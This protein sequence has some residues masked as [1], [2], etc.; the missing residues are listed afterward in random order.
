MTLTDE[1]GAG[2]PGLG[3]LLYAPAV[4]M[5]EEGLRVGKAIAHGQ[6][7]PALAPARVKGDLAI[8]PI[9]RDRAVGCAQPQVLTDQRER[10]RVVAV[11]ELVTWQSRCTRPRTQVP[12]SGGDGRQRAQQWPLDGEQRQRL[13][14]GST[15]HAH[16]GFFEYPVLG[17][18]HSDRPDCG[19]YPSKSC[20]DVGDPAF[21]DAFLRRVR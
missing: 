11:V 8:V 21:D 10:R 3:R 5:G 16:A 20:L 17:P 12:R 19:S 1:L 4:V 15:V 13:F 6:A 2:G 7:L 9:D 18:E 14:A